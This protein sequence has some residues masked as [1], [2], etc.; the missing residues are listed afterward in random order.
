MTVFQAE[1][2]NNFSL[3]MRINLAISID[4][5]R[6]LIIPERSAR[7][8]IVD[9]TLHEHYAVIELKLSQIF[10]RTFYICPV[11]GDG[12]CLYRAIYHIIFGT[13]TLFAELNEKL[14]QKFNNSP[15][16]IMNLL[17]MSGITCQ[18]D[19]NEHL[20]VIKK[21]NE[22]GTNVELTI[23]GAL[24]QIDVLIINATHYDPQLWRADNV[25]LHENLIIPAECSDIYNGNKLGVLLHRLNNCEQQYHFDLF[26]F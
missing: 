4:M 22:W 15:E 2:V 26:Y 23:L 17:H 3:A 14:L 24:A 19:L 9:K 10:G 13:E 20:N 1:S 12:N 18:Q 25:Y 5:A 21:S 16:H 11:I 7:Y 8:N 6:E